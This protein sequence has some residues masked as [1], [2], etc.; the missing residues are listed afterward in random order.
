MKKRVL[1]LLLIV[2]LA[3]TI[4]PSYAFAASSLS[5]FTK[6]KTNTAGQFTDVSDQWFA[7]NV[8]SAYEYGLVDGTS[9]NTFSPS[10]NL[11]IAEAIKL[12][13]CLN[14]IYDTGSASFTKGTTPGIS[15]MWITRCL[16]A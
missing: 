15:H 8:Q 6:A 14:S 3:L 10:K 11:T 13:A 7:P 4:L 9:P 1:S 16:M 5:N 2:V 12:A